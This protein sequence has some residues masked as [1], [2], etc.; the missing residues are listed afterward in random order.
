MSGNWKLLFGLAFVLV[1]IGW[2]LVVHAHGVSIEYTSNVEVEVVARYD[3]GGP[4]AGAQV[5]V[6]APDDPGTPWLTGTCDD[7]GRFIFTPDSSKP[8]TWD[9][10]VRLAGHG[11]MIH[12]P[13]GEGMVGTGGTGGYSVTQIVLMAVCVIWGIAGT[14]LYFMRKRA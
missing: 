11:G 3:T 14:A 8:G 6:Y 9:V 5:V 10:Q 2:P 12:I 13:V 7:D 1:M 4:M